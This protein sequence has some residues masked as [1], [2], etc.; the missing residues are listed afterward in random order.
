[1]AGEAA[2]IP[3]ADERMV[4]VK[5]EFLDY[6][7]K[8]IQD[9]STHLP[10]FFGQVI[11]TLDNSFP[12]LDAGTYDEFIDTVTFKILDTTDRG[13]EL[14]FI[15]KVIANALRSKKGPEGKAGLEIM[16]GMRL[17]KSEEFA[18]AIP[19]LKGYTDLDAMIAAAV[20]YC[21]YMLSLRE[22]ADGREKGIPGRPGEHE[23][24]A[25]EEMFRLG[26]KQPP[27]HAV[28]ALRMKEEEEP[29]LKRA[30]WLMLSSGLEWFP[31]ERGLIRVGLEKAKREGNQA[32]KVELLKIATERFYDDM[33]FLREMYHFRIEQRD[34]TGAAGV[35]RQMMQQFPQDLEPIYYGLKLSL[36][37]ARRPTYDGF[38]NLAMT[39][40]MSPEI[41]RLMDLCFSVV[42]S[43][44]QEALTRLYEIREAG[45]STRFLSPVLD[46]LIRDIFGD[47]DEKGLIAK[48]ALLDCVDGFTR[49]ALAIPL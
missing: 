37:S 22:M 13:R 17:L 44:Q 3:P 2:A 32:M 28:R 39:K 9:I 24:L 1:M 45:S 6:I 49:Q 33:S 7:D 10:V 40:G 21:Y 25:R 38:R 18:H 8:N 16:A 34:G 48:K 35:V 4:Q 23:L 42:S 31:N 47:D 20:A 5:H 27:I 15:E 14:P 36:L 26:R 30:F 11:S 29:W 12:N 46:Y 43:Q 41:V 19:F